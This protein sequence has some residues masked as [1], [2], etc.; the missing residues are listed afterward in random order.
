M[1]WVLNRTVS[2]RLFFE[3][4]KHM[5][6]LMDKKI[7]AILSFFFCLIGPMF[8]YSHAGLAVQYVSNGMENERRR[9]YIFLPGCSNNNII[10]P[11]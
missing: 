6:K 8:F 11:T 7:I 3:H 5:F 4:P 9:N 2:M 10:W 1:L